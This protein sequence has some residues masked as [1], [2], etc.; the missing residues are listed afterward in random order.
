ML[1]GT[2]KFPCTFSKRFRKVHGNFRV[3]LAK[4]FERYMEISVYLVAKDVKRYMEI[5]VYLE[6]KDVERYMEI[7]VYL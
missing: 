4:D 7:S 5:S 1:K 3:P 2:W 6:E